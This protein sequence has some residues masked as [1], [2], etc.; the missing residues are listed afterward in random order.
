MRS[1]YVKIFL[2]FWLAMVLV[3]GTLVFSILATQ[4]EFTQ[5]LEDANDRVVTPPYA[6]RYV[7]VFE[8]QG[9][10]A[11]ARYIQQ[12]KG[13][14][15]HVYL[16]GEDGKEELGQALPSDAKP[17][18]QVARRTDQTQIVRSTTRRFVAQQVTGPSGSHYIF[19]AELPLPF[20][21]FLSATPHIQ[22]FRLILAM[23]VG[24]LVCL[25]LA[26]YITAP[27]EKLQAAARQLAEGN[28][29]SRIGSAQRKDELGDLE[30]DFDRMAERIESLMS[31][32]QRLIQSISHELRSP[33]ARL[34]VALAL[35]QKQAG[36]GL[37]GPLNRIEREASRLN[38]LIGNLLTLSRWESGAEPV[39]KDIVQLDA[40]VREIAADAEFEATNRDRAV[41]VLALQPCSIAGRRDVLRSAIENVIRNAVNYTQEGSEVEVSLEHVRNPLQES[42][43]IRVRDHGEGVPEDALESIFRPFYRVADS[44]ERSSGGT[45]LGLFITSKA[46]VLHGGQ[47]RAKNVPTGGLLVELYFPLDGNTAELDSK[48]HPKL[49][50]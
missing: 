25:W 44:R 31:S 12:G 16:L 48:L 24:G 50:I 2:W 47:V 27:I 18:V 42:A 8:A 40:L 22:A 3:S 20:A 17:I 37:N 38:E 45:G 6:E 15:V 13:A 34:N 36:I 29:R 21:R 23:F 4:S 26:K 19:L 11:L 9:E 33:L 5:A 14:G 1:L 35:A 49:A 39:D 7:A 41:R 43:V 32:Q 30:R 28:L 46:V 10:A